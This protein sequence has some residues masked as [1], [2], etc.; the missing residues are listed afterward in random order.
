MAGN[1]RL[2]KRMD[3]SGSGLVDLLARA[4]LTVVGAI[5]I[6]AMLVSWFIARA[7]G[8]RTMFLM[9][10][11]G[12]LVI[13]ASWAIARRRLAI[14]VDRSDI[15]G[16]MREGQTS[17]VTLRITAN[18]RATT[19]I[20]NE[21][22]DPALGRTVRIPIASIGSG[23]ELLHTYSFSPSRRGV[24][25]IG[26]TSA[27]W[28]DPFGLTVQEQQLAGTT[29]LIV[30]PA[31]EG[32]HDR[33][34]T[35]MWEDPPIRPPSS[36]PWPTG[37]EFYGMRDYVPGDDLRRVVWSAVAKTGRML[38]RE[39]E[40]GIT[41]RVSIL[42]DTDREW[43]KPGNPSDTFET[44][45]R[46][47]ASIG[48]RHIKDGFNVNLSTNE[49]RLARN[50]RGPR[51]RYT[52]LDELAKVDMGKAPLTSIG[53]LL[54]DDARSGSHFVIITPHVDKQFANRLRQVLER[55]ASIVVVKIVWDE[56]DP[57]SLARAATLGCQVVQVPLNSS[58]QA[59]F[60]HQVGAGMRR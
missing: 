1:T 42:L 56:S 32:V 9:V 47:A 11:A 41:D 30:H 10:Y 7:L 39:S 29:T 3:S 22:L 59:A 15:P 21:Q 8:S 34:L 16:R 24:Y 25:Q 38:V 45:V 52:L 4:R 49:E 51:S 35:R 48:V 44:A 40:Q 26:P 20:L 54:A 55:G 58:V 50:L 46:V 6:G 37:F 14:D 19:L 27:T 53:P 5:L 31:T 23:E 57:Q 2:R 33:V 13:A 60:H 18:R 12:V 28:S 36:K 43:H 17:E